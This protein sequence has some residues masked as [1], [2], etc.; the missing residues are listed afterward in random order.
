M[1]VAR[2]LEEKVLTIKELGLPEI[3]ATLTKKT[4]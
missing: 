3:L 1:V 4:S 2:L